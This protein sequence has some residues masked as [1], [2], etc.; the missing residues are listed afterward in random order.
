MTLRN[1][2]F[3]GIIVALGAIIALEVLFDVLIDHVVG[4]QQVIAE[5]RAERALAA[6]RTRTE[7]GGTE[8]GTMV[9]SRT[10]D[11]RELL[12]RSVTGSA[13]VLAPSWPPDESPARWFTSTHSQAEGVS[14]EVAVEQRTFERALT[15]QLLLDLLDLPLFFAIA[16]LI[17]T[18]VTGRMQRPMAALNAAVDDIADRRQPRPLVVPKG[19]DEFARLARSFNAMNEAVQRYVDRER[20]FTRYASHELR[21]PLAALKVQVE[22]AQAR[23][24]DVAAVLPAMERNLTRMEFVIEALES[25]ARAGD[26]D[27]GSSLQPL[28]A[29]VE[30]PLAALPSDDRARVR[31]DVGPPDV[32]ISDGQLVRQALHNLIENALTYATGGI[33]LSLY[34]Q[35]S[36]LTLRVRDVGPGVDPADLPRLT[37]PFYRSRGTSGRGLGLG[38]SLVDV[39][40]R[41]LDGE[42][43]LRNTGKGFEATLRLPVV[44]P[45]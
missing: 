11:G 45:S 10:A 14:W 9:R 13:A 2:V 32:T 24:A 5:Q 22:R 36:S 41:A 25:L 37:E 34:A 19:D 23:T 4:H 15:N 16:F 33:T 1:T 40:A 27:A 26:R 30:D 3:W 7:E 8:F 12:V 21:T 6:F 38:L 18:A 20:T 43:D 42:L 35:H 31:I 44:L 28:R 39:I 29:V 17:A